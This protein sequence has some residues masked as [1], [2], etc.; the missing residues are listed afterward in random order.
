MSNK[1]IEKVTVEDVVDV[2]ELV[3]PVVATPTVYLAVEGDS[4]A[5]IAAKLATGTLTKFEY[6]K[7]LYDLNGG[8][9]LSEGTE[10]K[11]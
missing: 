8:K 3:E 10:V 2:V 4:Y 9:S 7:W 11:L 5:S 1:K 6:A